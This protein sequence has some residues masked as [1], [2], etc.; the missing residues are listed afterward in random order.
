LVFD[1]SAHFLGCQVA[2]SLS[3]KQHKLKKR[4]AWLSDKEV[5]AKSF[6][7]LYLPF[8]VAIDVAVAA[9]KNSLNSDS[10]YGVQAEATLKHLIQHLKQKSS[11]PEN[12]VAIF[13]GEFSSSELETVHLNIEEITPPEPIVSYLFEVNNTFQLAP[14][15]EMLR[16]PKVVG[17]LALDSKE[18]TLG[19]Q[20][21]KRQEII[22]ALTSGV[23]GKTGKG[24]QSQ[25]RYERERDMEVTAF[26]RR[27]A[28]HASREFLE[29]RQITALL[30]GGPGQ[31]KHDF[32]KGNFLHYELDNLLLQ[33]FDTQSAGKDAVKDILCKA[34]ELLKAMCG[35]EEKKLVERL[36]VE[37]RK[38]GSGLGTYGLDQV[39]GALRKGEAEVVL[40]TDDSNWFEIGALCKK[41][42]YKT[43]S[44][45]NGDKMQAMREL[46]SH[47]C[48]KCGSTAY[49]VME[50]DVVDVLEDV[51]SQTDARVEVI[52][53]PSNEKAQ[54]S[55][56]GGVAAVLRY[57][58]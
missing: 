37:L 17:V 47:P 40:V 54:L 23:P 43:T 22:D 18:A 29:N 26:F 35:P 33:T 8:N 16:D 19:L 13:A 36:Q 56:L 44:M 50:R 41:C 25:R 52:S 6:I 14:L 49:E 32:V 57:R 34:E 45:V 2:T 39:M 3:V 5:A 10:P 51:A 7:S 1:K 24:G 4:I 9:L 12:G 20:N 27:I 38:Q 58:R 21:G 55:A 31:T 48:P 53:S 42:S 30:V 46:I 28:E 11:L 15:R